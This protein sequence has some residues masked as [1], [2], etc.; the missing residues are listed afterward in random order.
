M[1]VLAC[2]KPCFA[3]NKTGSEKENVIS[4]RDAQGNLR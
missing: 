3:P 4:E 2:A 1:Q